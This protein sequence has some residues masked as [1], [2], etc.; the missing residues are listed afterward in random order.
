MITTTTG[1]TR[2]WPIAHRLNSQT[3]PAVEMTAI[4]PP[5]KT[6]RVYTFPRTA[7]ADWELAYAP[8]SSRLLETI[9]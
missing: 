9:S 5:W 8:V 1:R 3:S 4:K 7:T 2:L 6:L